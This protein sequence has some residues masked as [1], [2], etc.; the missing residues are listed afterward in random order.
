MKKNIAPQQLGCILS[1]FVFVAVFVVSL[2]Y[3]AAE[4]K[5]AQYEQQN[6]RKADYHDAAMR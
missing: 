4:T 1:I 3:F 2:V 6:Q 5:R